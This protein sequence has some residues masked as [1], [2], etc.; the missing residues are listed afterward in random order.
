MPGCIKFFNWVLLGLLLLAY[1][2]IAQ[3]HVSDLW[4]DGAPGAINN[5][6]YNKAWP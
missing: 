4:P 6:D 1:S 2:A 5:A 3:N